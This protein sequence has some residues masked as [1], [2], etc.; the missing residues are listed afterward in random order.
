LPPIRLASSASDVGERGRVTPVADQAPQ[1]AIS[2][3]G[4]A[5]ETS[6]FTW[7]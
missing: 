4:G 3:G 2:D 1:H 7:K 6:D 5:K